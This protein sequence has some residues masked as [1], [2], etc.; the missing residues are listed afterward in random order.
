MNSSM[1][2]LKISKPL[3]NKTIQ[4]ITLYVRHTRR[5]TRC[6]ASARVDLPRVVVVV[7]VRQRLTSTPHPAAP[8]QQQ[9]DASLSVMLGD[10]AYIYIMR[11]CV[12]HRMPRGAAH[13]R[14]WHF[15]LPSS[16]V[17]INLSSG[18][19]TTPR[20]HDITAVTVHCCTRPCT[21]LARSLHKV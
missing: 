4:I 15:P 2:K 14:K 20:S 13:R 19:T 17:V 1:K 5:C 16:S 11:H 7:V 21:G 6:A 10:G 8:P 18:Q 3:F 12:G 9:I